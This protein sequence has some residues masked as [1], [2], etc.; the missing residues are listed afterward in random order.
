M[1]GRCHPAPPRSRSAAF[2]R[3]FRL[4]NARHNWP[5]LG[6]VWSIGATHVDRLPPPSG[7]G[8]CSG[9]PCCV[10]KRTWFIQR[11][12]GTAENL[13]R[14][15]GNLE[16]IVSFRQGAQKAGATDRNLEGV[17]DFAKHGS[18]KGKYRN[19][20]TFRATARLQSSLRPD[21]CRAATQTGGRRW[22]SRS[23]RTSPTAGLR[24][25]WVAF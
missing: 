8:G 15:R 11:P 5:M 7:T 22:S 25:R 1:R 12:L 9:R 6:H 13:H 23:I 2:L 16:A 24:S 18:V 14:S 3:H 19:I 4:T 20:A 21:R 17:P 10:R